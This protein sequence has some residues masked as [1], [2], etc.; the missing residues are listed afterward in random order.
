MSLNY[1]YR[2]SSKYLSE[3]VSPKP[4]KTCDLNN[5]RSRT[6]LRVGDGAVLDNSVK[7]AWVVSPGPETE[8]DSPVICNTAQGGHIDVGLET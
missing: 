6:L 5:F 8:P 7:N 2:L 4:I 3:F 1:W